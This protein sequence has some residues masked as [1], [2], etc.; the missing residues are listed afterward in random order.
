[1]KSSHSP[2]CVWAAGILTLLAVFWT[3]Y[4]L[5]AY[6]IFG[7]GGV[8]PKLG[9]LLAAA[10]GTTIVSVGL[11]VLSRYAE[12]RAAAARLVHEK[13]IAVYEQLMQFLFRTL[14]ATRSGEPLPEADAVKFMTNFAQRIMV[15]GSDEVLEAWSDFRT[16]LGE[17]ARA[18]RA[19]ERLVLTVRR[20]LGHENRNLGPG[21]MLSLVLDDVETPAAG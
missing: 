4:A 21:T 13:K 16:A 11:V 5:F 6:V 12:S 7:L 14:L 2:Y 8:D 3:V 15:W 9:A 1:M 10:A 19:Y 18:M 20:D 17:P